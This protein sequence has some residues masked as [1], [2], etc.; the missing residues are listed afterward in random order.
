[1]PRDHLRCNTCQRRQEAEKWDAK[2]EVAWD[3]EFPIAIWDVDE[4]FFDEDALLEFVYD[5]ELTIES[6]RLTSCR[7]CKPPRFDMSEYLT[8]WLA[9]D[10]EVDCDEINETVNTWIAEHKPTTWVATGQ[11]LS[12][13][14]VKR[15]LG[16]EE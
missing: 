10:Q 1:M 8:D 6:L 9:E 15:L 16:I 11:R 3:G 5:H 7:V 12:L 4:F 2:P 13:A 14:S